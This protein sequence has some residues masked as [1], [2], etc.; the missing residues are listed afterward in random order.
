MSSKRRITL[1]RAKTMHYDGDKN[2][3]LRSKTTLLDIEPS[4]AGI[5]ITE[6]NLFQHKKAARNTNF[7]GKVPGG[8]VARVDVDLSNRVA[9]KI[10]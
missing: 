4:A 5:G 6:M 10:Q 1:K 9:L 7:G 2:Q 8:I 3:R